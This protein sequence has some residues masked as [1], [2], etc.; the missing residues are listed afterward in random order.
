[1]NKKVAANILRGHLKPVP[2]PAA[3]W[4]VFLIPTSSN[5]PNSSD[6]SLRSGDGDLSEN[7]DVEVEESVDSPA[8]AAFNDATTDTGR[9]PSAVCVFCNVTLI[10]RLRLTL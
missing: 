6:S 8:N 3:K 4:K 7:A 5:A 10:M 1:M 2:R 9:L